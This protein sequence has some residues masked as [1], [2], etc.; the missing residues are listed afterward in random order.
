MFTIRALTL[1]D[2]PAL[3][4]IVVTANDHA[5]RGLL[6]DETLDFPESES[7]AN[8]RHFL[9]GEGL[10]EGDFMLVAQAENGEVVG[11]IWGGRNWKEKAFAGELRQINILPAYQGQGIGRLLM[12]H[13]ARRFVAQG[14]S[15]VRV[16]VLKINPNR[17]FYERLGGVFVREFPYAGD[18]FTVPAYVYGWADIQTLLVH[19]HAV[20]AP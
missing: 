7:A 11:Y 9:E 15:S 4:H 5:F 20:P 14:I 18:V 16:E 17:P 19:C 10:P 13:L 8:W 3:A 2:I 1:D 12:C 6:P